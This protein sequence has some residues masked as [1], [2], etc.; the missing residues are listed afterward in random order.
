MTTTGTTTVPAAR[1]TA[2]RTFNRSYTKF[3]GALNEG[4]LHSPYSLTEARILF[5]LAQRDSTEVAEL[6]R[7][8]DLDA[9]YLSRVL[10][11]FEDNNLVRRERSATDGRRQVVRLTE[12]GR[13]TFRTL[14]ARSTEQVRRLLSGLDETG[15]RSLVDAMDVIKQQ[16]ERASSNAGEVVLRP[17]GPG[18]Y[19][20]VVH[21]NGLWYARE[22][23]WDHG[24]EGLVA[25]IIADYLE[26]HDPRRE[27][28]WIAEL[29]GEPVGSVFCVREDDVTAKLRLLLVEPSARG[30][31]VGTRLVDECVSFAR[32][33]GYRAMQLWTVDKLAAAR[34]IYQRAGFTLVA[35]ERKALFGDEVVGQTWRLEL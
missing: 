24:Y 17:P 8:L 4:L 19:G 7:E 30:A 28:G 12:H 32:K 13:G 9:G 35:E 25:R 6:R 23:G 16:V 10:A 2:V 18:D 11:R 21:R 22:Y 15:Q 1:I 20:W 3:L 27:A 34:R 31:G 33:V 14:D 5:E 26:D 29:R